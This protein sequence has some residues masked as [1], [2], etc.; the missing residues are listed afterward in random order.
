MKFVIAR[1]ELNDLISQATNVVGAKATIPILSNILIEAANDELI[2]T[3]TDLTVGVRCFAKAKVLE[4]GATTVPAKRFAQLLRELTCHNVEITDNGND[5]VEIIADSSRFKMH[6]MNKSEY[7]SLPDF[8]GAVNFTIKPE[9]LK[10]LLSRTSFAVSREDNRYVLMGVCMRIADGI[11][12]FTGTDGRRLARTYIDIGLDKTFKGEY[13]LPIKAVDEICK[14]LSDDEEQP[15][16][17]YLMDDKVAVEGSRAMVITKL[18]S[19][20]YPDIDRV[21]PQSNEHIVTLHREE[22]ITLLRQIS[23]FTAD[24]SHSVR[25][26]FSD[27]ELKLLANTIDVGEGKVSM[28]VNYGGQKLD[29]AF[30]PGFFLDILRHSKEETVNIGLTDSYNPGIISDAALAESTDTP[31]NPLY[32]LM[33]MRLNEE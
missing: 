33:P 2:I 25:F 30:N 7:P 17:M 31:P 19:G 26:T 32:V 5:V 13:V 22:L 11:A 14:A 4:Q 8:T 1:Q 15:V 16:T 18:I 21:I 3:A 9:V 12:V 29:I 10:S 24:T 27:G 23:L 6:G 20:E 28:P